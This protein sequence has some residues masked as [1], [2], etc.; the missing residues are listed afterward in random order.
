MKTKLV[1]ALAL[2]LSAC[3]IDGLNI[4]KVDKDGNVRSL[5]P[6]NIPINV[7][8]TSGS[9]NLAA[10]SAYSMTMTGCVSGYSPTVTE[11]TA[12][13]MPVYRFD[14]GCIA[15]LRSFTT[16]G[17]EYRFDNPNATPFPAAHA[18]GNTA[19]FT[20][21]TG[22]LFVGVSVI[23]QLDDPISGT[24][25]IQYGFSE[26][27]AGTGDT[28]TSGTVGASHT[29]TV[30]GD[31]APNVEVQAHG[32]T[33]MTAAGEG[34]FTFAMEC[35]G[36]YADPACDT[37]DVT[38]YQWALVEDTYGG[39]PTLPD[40]DAITMSGLFGTSNPAIGT[41]GG[42]DSPTLTGPATIHS[43]PNM[44]LVIKNGLSYKYMTVQ[45][46]VLTP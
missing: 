5:T 35:Q 33:G 39:T 24:E 42:V 20:D 26:S 8:D 21:G 29:I 17:T 40:L 44:L 2:G 32:Y 14:Q 4:G 30:A 15:E 12:G 10:A 25:P 36:T 23:A 34:Q 46:Q 9:F 31:G 43:K 27:V 3:G 7:V 22:T 41:N 38:T 11:A 45:V 13:G 16:G 6:I 1:F 28:I 37:I 19:T 18:V